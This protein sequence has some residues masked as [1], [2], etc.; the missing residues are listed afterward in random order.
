MPTYTSLPEFFQKVSE[1]LQDIGDL[2][3][4]NVAHDDE[5]RLQVQELAKDLE[6][7]CSQMKDAIQGIDFGGNCRDCLLRWLLTS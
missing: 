5:G 2:P 3:W 7:I 6:C 1:R 4:D